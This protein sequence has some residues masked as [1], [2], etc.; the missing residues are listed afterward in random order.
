MLLTGDELS[1]THLAKRA[2]LA[3]PTVRSEVARL[4]DAGIVSERQVGRTRLFR[5]NAE[6]PLVDPLR[7][8]LTVVTGPAVMLAEGFT[9][10][11]PRQRI[12]AVTP[13]SA[14]SPPLQRL[15]WRTVVVGTCHIGVMICSRAAVVP[16]TGVDAD[17]DP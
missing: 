13:R 10:R 14:H 2:G 4:M 1:V 16:E 3:Y 9:R 8:I 11:R 5:A 17:S 12:V 15:T 7:E 6:S